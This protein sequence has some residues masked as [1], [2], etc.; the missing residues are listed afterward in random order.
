LIATIRM[1]RPRRLVQATLAVPAL[2][3]SCATTIV[4]V[5]G[6]VPATLS[7]SE[8]AVRVQVSV[9]GTARVRKALAVITYLP[10]GSESVELPLLEAVK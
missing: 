7:V 10:A 4:T 8:P 3:N 6:A 5:A 2:V 9:P 1:V